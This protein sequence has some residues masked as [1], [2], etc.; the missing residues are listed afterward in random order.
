MVETVK[1]GDDETSKVLNILCKIYFIA[2]GGATSLFSQYISMQYTKFFLKAYDVSEAS[3]ELQLSSEDAE[4]KSALRCKDSLSTSGF[5]FSLTPYELL[6][7][8]A[9]AGVHYDS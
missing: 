6:S 3:L 5:V 9:E 1:T 8:H 7:A 4:Y 2:N